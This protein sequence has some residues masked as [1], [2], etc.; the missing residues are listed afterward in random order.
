MKEQ[1]VELVKKL[2]KK[3]KIQGFLGLREENGSVRPYLFKKPGELT[4]MSLGDKTK[5]GDVRYPLNSTLIKLAQAYPDATIGV[6]VRGCDARGL[7]EL[8]K[9]KQLQPEKVVA[10]GIA[11]PAELAKACE[12][13]QPY[14][15]DCQVGKKQKGVKVQDSVKKVE[16]LPTAERFRQWMDH[17]ERCVKCYGCRNVCPM[18]FCKECALEETDLVETAVL[19]TENPIFHLTRAVH[20]A[21]RCIDCGLCEEACP[22]DIPL[23]ALY[24]KVADIL[25]SETGYR[26]GFQPDQKSPLNIIETSSSSD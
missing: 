9:W 11:C 12:C 5:P 17:F 8:F 13:L 24:K 7:V 20:M 4:E 15:D 2:L 3:G 23:R 1:V 14:P 6:L 16:K 18:C 21:G 10:V 22:A 19:P 26:P 25:A